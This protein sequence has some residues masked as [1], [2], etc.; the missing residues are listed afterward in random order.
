MQTAIKLSPLAF[1]RQI[2]I[3]QIASVASDAGMHLIE[4]M[5][6]M[7]LMQVSALVV[8]WKLSKVYVC[9]FFLSAQLSRN[10]TLS[11]TVAR[12]FDDATGT[13]ARST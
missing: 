12:Y 9:F 10:K 8:S 4:L 5:L 11:I 6:M 1:K 7:L 3:A 13:L 2:D